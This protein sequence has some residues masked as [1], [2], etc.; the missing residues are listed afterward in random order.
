MEDMNFQ[1]NEIAV[2]L[3]IGTTKICAM[4]GRL[5]EYGKIEILGVGLSSPKGYLEE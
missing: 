2:A 4:A 3:D 5:N 1:K